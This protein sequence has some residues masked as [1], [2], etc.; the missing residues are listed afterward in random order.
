MDRKLGE[1]ELPDSGGARVS[2]AHLVYSPEGLS[3]TICS[4]HFQPLIADEYEET[5]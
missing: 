3:P 5:D 1:Q 4:A 2:Y